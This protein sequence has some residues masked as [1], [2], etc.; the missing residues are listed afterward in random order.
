MGPKVQALP[1]AMGCC[2]KARR[3]WLPILKGVGNVI[4][5]ECI[6]EPVGRI[7]ATISIQPTVTKQTAML[8][9]RRNPSR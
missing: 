3:R 9:K 2:E 1:T 5:G 7:R 6:G 8:F 4:L